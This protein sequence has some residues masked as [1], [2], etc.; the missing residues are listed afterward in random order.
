MFETLKL[1]P[2]QHFYRF[3]GNAAGEY[4]NGPPAAA[5][6][7]NKHRSAASRRHHNRHDSCDAATPC[8][9]V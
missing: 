4:H 3:H 9:F 7:I 1:T 8:P 5:A 2:E 6:D